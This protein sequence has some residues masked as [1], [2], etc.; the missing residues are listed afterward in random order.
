MERFTAVGENANHYLNRPFSKETD[1]G[2]P[3]GSLVPQSLLHL[4]FDPSER[5]ETGDKAT[6]KTLPKFDQ[7]TWHNLCLHLVLHQFI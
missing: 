2:L 3:E 5:D 7:L 6:K 4:T 1:H